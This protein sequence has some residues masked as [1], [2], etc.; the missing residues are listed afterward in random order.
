MF[1]AP[2]KVKHYSFDCVTLTLRA[3]H[4]ILVRVQGLGFGA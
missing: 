4:E 3:V 1:G 2:E